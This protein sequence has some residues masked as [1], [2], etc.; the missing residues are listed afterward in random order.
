[1]AIG[2]DP[3]P[4]Q[5]PAQVHVGGN[6]QA[7][8]QGEVLEDDRDAVL[9]GLGR[10]GERNWAAVDEHFSG[11]H[12]VDAGEH[13]DHCGLAGP[14]VADEHEHRAGIGAQKDILEG[15]HMAE[16]LRHVAQ[17]QCGRASDHM[18][19]VGNRMTLSRSARPRQSGVQAPSG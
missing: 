4:A 11:V 9:P 15:D 2:K 8:D 18:G 7:F 5:G 10:A 12:R 17:F 6:I 19:F 1:V 3:G 16:G 13:L 14:V